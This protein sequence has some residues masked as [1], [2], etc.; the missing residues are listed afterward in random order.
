GG[1][2]IVER[3]LEGYGV[4]APG[5]V[6]LLHALRRGEEAGGCGCPGHASAR[7][8]L[9]S[10]LAEAFDVAVLDMEAGLGHVDRAEG[11][12]AAVDA[13]LVVADPTRKSLVTAGALVARARAAGVEVVALVGNQ[14]QPGDAASFAGA[15]AAH[16]TPLAAV[17]PH[18]TAVA[19]ADRAG[20][21]VGAAP[22]PVGAA[23]EALVTWLLPPADPT[24]E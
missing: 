3:L 5:G 1:R 13:L 2:V 9:A 6:T 8:L 16:S 23:V 12:L 14:A 10:A 11:T 24:P 7:G 20:A 18:S 17:I 21:G 4:A 19:A 22:P 15:A